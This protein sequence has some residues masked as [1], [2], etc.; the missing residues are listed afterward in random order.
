MSAPKVCSW[1]METTLVPNYHYVLLKDDFSNLKEKLNWCNDNPEI[2]KEIISNA[3]HFMSQFSNLNN[4][5]E[6]EKR[7]INKY[8]EILDNAKCGNG[9][10]NGNGNKN[11]K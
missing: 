9:N 5:I 7:V 1:L 4:E 6:L 3:N 2:C 8:F 11:N 10:G